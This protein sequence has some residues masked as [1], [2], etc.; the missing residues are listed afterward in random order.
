VAEFTRLIC[1]FNERIFSI[2]VVGLVLGSLSRI[3]NKK[4]LAF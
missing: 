2:V 3:P 4:L 1:Y